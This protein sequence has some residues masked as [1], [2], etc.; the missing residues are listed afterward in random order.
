MPRFRSAVALL[1]G[2][3]LARCGVL[4]PFETL[5]PTLTKAEEQIPGGPPQRVAVC[6][7]A[8]TTTAA[9]VRAI[10][11][12]ECAAGTSPRAAGRDLA[13]S[14]CPLLQP[15]R[16]TFLCLKSGQADSAAQP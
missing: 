8:L 16:V 9:K 10:A 11:E 7:N 4:P 1:V 14:Y 6:Y 2:L 3:A 13:L 12:A 5:P 15:E